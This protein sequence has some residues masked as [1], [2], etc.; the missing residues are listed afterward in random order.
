MSSILDALER[1]SQE[2]MPGKTDILPDKM[3]VFD[4]NKTVFH[5]LLL[6]AVLLISI[7]ASFWFLFGDGASNP[8]TTANAYQMTNPVIRPQATPPAERDGGTETVRQNKPTVPKDE[9]TAERIR[10]SSRPNQRPLISEA[11]VSEKQQR[12]TLEMPESVPVEQATRRLPTSPVVERKK[13]A[14]LLA[15]I[16]EEVTYAEKSEQVATMP[17]VDEDQIASVESTVNDI[18]DAAQ[19]DQQQIPLI[20]E[21]DQGL[22][23]ELEQLRTTIHVYHEIPSERFVIINM[24]RYGE[25]DTLDAKGYRL[26]TID[27]DGIV[28]DYGNGLV[29]LLREKY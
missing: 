17:E 4:E 20:W 9:L 3:P 24:R 26:H 6:L 15:P 13:P 19:T 28:V 2:R 18:A 1:A 10:S 12:K 27:R 16:A 22:R 21:L 5:R 25:G 11:I 29:R 7:I 8:Y 14:P 23:E